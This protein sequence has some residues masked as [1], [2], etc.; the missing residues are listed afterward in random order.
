MAGNIIALTAMYDSTYGDKWKD[1][2]ITSDVQTRVQQAAEAWDKFD[3]HIQTQ[4]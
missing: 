1:F 3:Q 4:C 2:H